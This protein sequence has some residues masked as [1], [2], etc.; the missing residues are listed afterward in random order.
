MARN[1][2]C[3]QQPDNEQKKRD[4]TEADLDQYG[5]Y[6]TPEFAHSYTY[7]ARDVSKRFCEQACERGNFALA[8]RYAETY[9]R[10]RLSLLSWE[11][12]GCA[13][14]PATRPPRRVPEASQR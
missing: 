11:C 14:C 3:D 5:S 9:E 4:W 10:A 13:I 8:R 1:A 2:P 7:Y 6:A 12:T